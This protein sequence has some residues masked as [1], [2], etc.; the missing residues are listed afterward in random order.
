MV[1]LIT[2]VYVSLS[3][4]ITSSNL[5]V[6]VAVTTTPA[7]RKATNFALVSLAMADLFVGVIVLPLRIVEVWAF[8]L[9]RSLYWCQCSLSLTLLSLSASVLNLS[10]VTADRYFS[11][12][13]PLLYQSK[14][15]SR[16]VVCA[17]IFVWAVALLVSFLPFITL[18]S[19]TAK[20]RSH[21]HKICRFADT[22]SPGYLTFF[23]CIAVLIPTLFMSYAYVRMYRAASKLKHRLKRLQ[24]PRVGEEIVT[25]L[26]E[27]K[28]AKTIGK[29][30]VRDLFKLKTV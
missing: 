5:L 27:S 25:A 8:H 15:T 21:Q 16:R 26:K 2:F 9:S 1:P 10:I 6:I 14:I 12:I 18:K 3:C 7:L 22:M 4:L 19:T 11:V 23:V 29:L 30:I 28:A 20:E 17:L 13:L 24:V